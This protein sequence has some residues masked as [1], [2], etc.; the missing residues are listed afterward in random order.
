M[1]EGGN[2]AIPNLD[3]PELGRRYETTRETEMKKLLIASTAL[4]LVAGAASA[5]VTFSGYGRFGLAYNSTDGNIS[6]SDGGH[7]AEKSKLQVSERLQLNIDVSK[8]T[9]SGITFGGRTRLRWNANDTDGNF[10]PADLYVKSGGLKVEVG[11]ANEAIDSMNTYYNGEIGLTG[12]GNADPLNYAS[13]YFYT[14]SSQSYSNSG[15]VGVM[16]TYSVGDFV[17][18]LSYYNPNQ[19]A[20]NLSTWQDHAAGE[21]AGSVDYKFGDLQVGAGF[22]HNAGGNFG[23]NLYL[24]TAEYAIGDTNIGAVVA[25]ASSFQGYVVSSDPG[26]LPSTTKYVKGFTQG[27]LYVNHKFGPVT[28]AGYIN[29]SNQDSAASYDG[30]DY[31]KMGAGIGASYDLGSGA[32]LTGSYQRL[33]NGENYADLGVVFSF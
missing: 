3:R 24:V 32:R 7:T 12:N 17:G 18:R 28:L 2:R 6:S 5:D 14:F 25:R 11:N 33:V 8:T 30:T 22:A 10:S 4:T 9:D 20:K 23:A 1:G 27:E 13:A 21:L 19:Q 15:Q 31:S 16:A 26:N 29:K